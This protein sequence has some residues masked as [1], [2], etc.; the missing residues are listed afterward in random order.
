MM[1]PKR[2][3]NSR[4]EQVL[5]QIGFLL[6]LLSAMGALLLA[7][8]QLRLKDKTYREEFRVQEGELFTAPFEVIYGVGLSDDRGKKIENIEG[9]QSL[10]TVTLSICNEAGE[11]VYTKMAEEVPMDQPGTVMAKDLITKSYNLLPDQKYSIYLED[12]SG[13]RTDM[14]VFLY[15]E[16]KSPRSFYTSI[17][18]LIMLVTLLGGIF[19]LQKD[20]IPL[21][22]SA[23]CM[24]LALGL[25]WEIAQAPLSAPDEMVHFARA[26]QISSQWLG[27]PQLDEDGYPLVEGTGLQKMEFNGNFQ[28][29]MHFWEDTQGNEQGSY[30]SYSQPPYLQTDIPYYL[31]AAAITLCRLAGASYQWIVISGRVV[32]LLLYTFV[33][34]L[35]LRM[36]P[37]IHERLFASL[38]F[39]PGISEVACS[40]SY[41]IWTNGFIFLFMAVCLHCRDVRRTVRRR[42][43]A[44]LIL[45]AALMTPVKVI[46]ILMI[47]AIYLIPRDRFKKRWHRPALMLATFLAA[48]LVLIGIQWRALSVYLLP[49]TET[50]TVAMVSPETEPESGSAAQENELS[51]QAVAMVASEDADAL[52][53]TA[54]WA[55][56]DG[57][58]KANAGEVTEEVGTE[59][60]APETTEETAVVS[61][62][63]SQFTVDWILAHPVKTVYIL[64]GDLFEET[65][66][67][68]KQCLMGNGIP[69]HASS[70]LLFFAVLTV[71]LL[72]MTQGLPND[73]V[74][75]K[76]R[77][78]GIIMM[79]AGLLTVQVT[80]LIT[81][82]GFQA[83]GVSPIRGI[84]GRYFI[85][86]LLFLPF[87]LQNR[88]IVLSEKTQ[89]RLL[90]MMPFLNICTALS[91]IA[92]IAGR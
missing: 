27:E 77:F 83:E 50:D 72:L 49:Q 66:Y 62:T 17:C 45:F 30:Y 73:Y 13:E 79:L 46:Y 1:H 80:F 63:P 12:E 11:T 84:Q 57:E 7:F 47:P 35:A 85:P 67:L 48:G 24:F 71:F 78:A 68:A 55:E 74:T 76:E 61:Q 6:L 20:R 25:L 53:D 36:A 33:L 70:D 56:Q 32:N 90:W 37:G 31:P 39:L 40:Y 15:G 81:T 52:P 8:W 69:L 21:R 54:L 60:E 38:C 75:G 82:T 19:Y 5:F 86:Y 58:E 16:E 88:R 3:I 10:A 14:T 23:P 41:D 87:V 89:Q 43:V 26:Y 92:Y 59:D 64:A 65:D 4:K 51:L 9:Y 22:I 2:K 28:Y 18:I 44:A 42:D 29:M 91:T 34:W